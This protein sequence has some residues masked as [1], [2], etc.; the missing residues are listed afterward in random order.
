MH[1]APAVCL[2]TVCVDVQAVR[3]ACAGALGELALCPKGPGV[4]A[5]LEAEKKPAKKLQVE[6]VAAGG[7]HAALVQPLTEA[8]VYGRKV[9]ARQ[10]KH[11]RAFCWS[12]VARARVLL[13]LT[14]PPPPPTP[15]GYRWH[16][17]P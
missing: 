5:A 3:D 12:P 13:C 6:K 4:A 10:G 2:A 1:A 7:F 11:A 17:Y 9:R 14:P 8:A 15:A 16:A